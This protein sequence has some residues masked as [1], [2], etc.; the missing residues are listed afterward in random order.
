MLF[1]LA[2]SVFSF[3][4]G[5]NF[6]GTDDYIQTSYSGIAGTGNRTIETWIR[7]TDNYNPSN[8]GSQGVFS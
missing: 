6:D 4:Q 5:I 2:C 7:T 3:G 8:G 1:F